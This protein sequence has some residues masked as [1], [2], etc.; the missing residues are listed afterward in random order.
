MAGGEA[1]LQLKLLYKV[2]KH[3]RN[4]RAGNSV[5]EFLINI[6]NSALQDIDIYVLPQIFMILPLIFRPRLSVFCG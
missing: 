2:S 6:T 1:G 3:V 4:S 5:H